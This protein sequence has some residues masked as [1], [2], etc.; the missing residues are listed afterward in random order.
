MEIESFVPLFTVIKEVSLSPQNF[1]GMALVYGDT[2]ALEYLGARL[3]AKTFPF[4]VAL[5]ESCVNRA[6]ATVVHSLSKNPSLSSET[7]AKVLLSGFVSICIALSLTLI[8]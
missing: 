3:G 6:F 1:V 7:L 8:L 5:V 4:E 2:D